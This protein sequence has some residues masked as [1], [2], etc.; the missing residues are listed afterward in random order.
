M[1]N[2]KVLYMCLYIIW[3]G[4]NLIHESLVPIINYEYSDIYDDYHDDYSI[5]C[6]YFG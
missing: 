3:D 1:K 5:P 4:N 2:W 6:D